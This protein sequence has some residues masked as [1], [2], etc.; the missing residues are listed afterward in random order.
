M[1]KQQHSVNQKSCPQILLY[2]SVKQRMFHP[3]LYGLALVYFDNMKVK[4]VDAFPWRQKYRFQSE[5]VS[6]VDKNL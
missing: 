2:I 6:Y 5:I 3:H 4:A 1:R